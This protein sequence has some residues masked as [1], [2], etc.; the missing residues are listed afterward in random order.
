V[1]FLIL[2]LLGAGHSYI[3]IQNDKNDTQNTSVF[4]WGK[5]NFGQL[6]HGE[7]EG[8]QFISPLIS[9]LLHLVTNS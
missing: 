7:Q 2:T 5:C 6:G 9:L 8:I 1:L 3:I 4:S